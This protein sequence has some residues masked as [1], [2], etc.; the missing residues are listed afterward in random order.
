MTDS[1]QQV[2]STSDSGKTVQWH[3]GGKKAVLDAYLK[4]HEH[5]IGAHWLW[6]AIQR[7]N[8]GESELS[9]M[10]DFGY[11]PE[12]TVPAKDEIK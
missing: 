6:C 1:K 3:R 2:D 8:N 7:I 10:E 11:V 12:G 9:V 4:L 5:K